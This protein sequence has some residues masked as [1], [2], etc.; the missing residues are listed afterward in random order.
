MELFGVHV[1]DVGLLCRAGRRRGGGVQLGVGGRLVGADGVVLAVR[2]DD[3]RAQQ[4]GAVDV[5]ARVPQ[6]A[7]GLLMRVG[8]YLLFTPQEMTPISG[9]TAFK[10]R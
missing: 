9:R 3:D 1:A 8:R 4:V 5:Y 7:Q 10:K 2:P 6:D